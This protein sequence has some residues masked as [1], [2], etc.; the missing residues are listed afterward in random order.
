MSFRS[1]RCFSLLVSYSLKSPPL[2]DNDISSLFGRLYFRFGRL[3]SAAEIYNIVR[4]PSI[5]RGGN[6]QYCEIILPLL[7]PSPVS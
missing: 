2:T 4:L 5:I 7:L 6:L 3:F 1:F